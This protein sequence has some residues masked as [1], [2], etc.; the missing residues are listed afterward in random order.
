MAQTYLGD[1]VFWSVTLE[2][3]KEISIGLN[4]DVHSS[5]RGRVSNDILSGHFI[6][7]K[8]CS[9]RLH[10]KFWLFFFFSNRIWVRL[11]S[12][13]RCEST[14]PCPALLRFHRN[15]HLLQRDHY[16]WAGLRCMKCTVNE[17]KYLKCQNWVKHHV[18]K[19]VEQYT[20]YVFRHSNNGGI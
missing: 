17:R 5:P 14:G 7:L 3:D 16:S 6:L 10:W 9:R 2:R 19:N 8:T 12:S 15:G 1:G 20:R 13:V 18:T 4:I 11:G